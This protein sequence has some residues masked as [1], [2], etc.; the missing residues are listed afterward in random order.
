MITSN[1]TEK[2]HWLSNSLYRSFMHRMNL[3]RTVLIW[4]LM[5]DVSMKRKKNID[6]EVTDRLIISPMIWCPISLNC[7]NCILKDWCWGMA[8]GYRSAD[9]KYYDLGGADWWC[10][11]ISFSHV[12]QWIW[13]FLFL[14]GLASVCIWHLD[15]DYDGSVNFLT[16]MIELGVVGWLMT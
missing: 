11:V 6:M 12:V 14:V 2:C 7:N 4:F 5:F 16:G 10:R 9:Y 3:S 15:L 8:G 13:N 1:V